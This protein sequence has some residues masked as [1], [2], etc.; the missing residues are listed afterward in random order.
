MYGRGIKTVKHNNESY[1][2][3]TILV[4]SAQLGAIYQ[5]CSVGLISDDDFQLVN[6]VK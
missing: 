4:L 6:V 1:E 2:T 5:L 3:D